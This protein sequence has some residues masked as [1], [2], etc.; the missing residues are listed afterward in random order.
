MFDINKTTSKTG[1]CFFSAKKN[2]DANYA[3]DTIYEYTWIINAQDYAILGSCDLI[4]KAY[5]TRV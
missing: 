2:V 3:T 4:L 1:T 5:C